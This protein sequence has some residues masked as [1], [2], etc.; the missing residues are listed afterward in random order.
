VS[1]F[2]LVA[3]IGPV[4]VLYEKD[5]DAPLHVP[6]KRRINGFQ[7]PA[8]RLRGRPF[9]TPFERE[10]LEQG[11]CSRIARQGTVAIDL[12][13]QLAEWT[14]RCLNELNAASGGENRTA[15]VHVQLELAQ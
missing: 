7:Q 5:D 4:H 9:R 6:R 10:A 8:R 11:A 13:Q 3:T 12:L 2:A 15:S 14:E 1:L